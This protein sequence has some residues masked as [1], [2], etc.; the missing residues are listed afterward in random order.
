MKL[1]S[2]DPIHYGIF[3]ATAFEPYHENNS[4]V[5]QIQQT[6]VTCPAQLDCMA[7]SLG[8]LSS[9]IGQQYQ[10]QQTNEIVLGY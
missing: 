5:Q 1:Y 7:Y 4:F 9:N 10:Q 3:G 6:A 2:L 8:L